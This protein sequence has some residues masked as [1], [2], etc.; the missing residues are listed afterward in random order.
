MQ[1][2]NVN[3]NNYL[4]HGFDK[5]EGWCGHGL[6]EIVDYLDRCGFNK[7]GGCLEIGVHHGKFYIMLNSIIDSKYQSYAIDVFDEQTLNIDKSGCG[8]L[9]NF[10]K[11]L[12]N[13]DKHKG[14][15]TII[16]Q[17]DSTDCKLIR[18]IDIPPGSIRYLSIDGGHTVEHTVSDLELAKNLL[19]NEGVVILDDVINYHWLGVIE[20]VGKFLSLKPTLVPF[21]IGH[22]K[23]FFSKLSYQKR[24]FDIFFKSKMRTKE[25]SFYGHQLVAL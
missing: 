4:N 23:L 15:N 17:G 3:L 16:I 12:R 19:S 6:F 7:A 18:E 13:F 11:N 24:Y 1:I 21:A 10:K 20:G 8:S 25:V 5:V 14:E 9:E 2:Q 22:N